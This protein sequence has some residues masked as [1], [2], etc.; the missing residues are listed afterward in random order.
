MFAGTRG[1]LRLARNVPT[2]DPRQDFFMMAAA[3]IQVIGNSLYSWWSAW[4]RVSMGFT[5]RVFAPAEW[6][7][8]PMTDLYPQDWIQIDRQLKRP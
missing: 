3:R 8:F 5:R 1:F 2:N 6:S 7:L 4:L